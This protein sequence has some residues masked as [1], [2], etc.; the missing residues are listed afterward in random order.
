MNRQIIVVALVTLALGAAGGYWFART[1]TPHDMAASPQVQ[2]AAARP[3][4][5]RH[6]M[7][8]QITSPVPVKDNMN[9]DY[10][11]VYADDTPG[12]AG[13]VKIDP[14]TVQNI[15][16]RTARAERRTMGHTIRAAGRVDYNEEGL[17][18]LNPKTEGWVDKLMVSTTGERVRRGTVLL[19]LYSPQLVTAQQEY[20]LA[21]QNRTALKDSTYPELQ[22]N[23]SQLVDAARGRLELLDMPEHQILELE[24]SNKVI[25]N[26]HIHSPF[27]GVVVS[28]GARPGQYVTPATELYQIAD[29]ERLW[30]Y[31][32]I[33]ENELPWVHVGDNAQMRVN[34]APGRAV[35]GKVT[36]IY[37]TVDAKTRTVRLRLEFANR[38]G[39]LKPDMFA[40]VTLRGGRTLNA[41]AVPSE[42]VVRSGAREQVFIMRAPGKFEP[43]EVQIGVSAEGWTEIRAGVSVDDIVVTSAQF[44]IDSESKLR[45]AV[46]KMREPA[47]VAAPAAALDMSDMDMDNAGVAGG[48]PSP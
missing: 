17:A 33:Y 47:P 30:V 9:M 41:I 5:Y 46:G 1:G 35:E 23:A 22:R 42:A 4:F 15:G 27:D 29:L 36:Y 21:L 11:P 12:P 45:E 14:V 48:Q 18:R 24:R 34:A 3:L 16:V 38:D 43:R 39:L 20:L 28:I 10:I 37:P 7:N 44:L 6:P 2:P 13:T 31:V 8:P 40:E 26:L 25:K 19:S 32:D